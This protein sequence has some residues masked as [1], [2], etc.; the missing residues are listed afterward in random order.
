MPG[1][2]FSPVRAEERN[3]PVQA[4]I[5]LTAIII[6]LVDVSVLGVSMPQFRG[7]LSLSELERTTP[8][9]QDFDFAPSMLG[10]PFSKT[11]RFF[12]QTSY[13]RDY[14]LVFMQHG[15]LWD[16]DGGGYDL[17]FQ[18]DWSPGADQHLEPGETE[19]VTVTVALP[20]SAEN[21]CQ[22]DTGRLIVRRGYLDAGQAG[23]V[24]ECRPS[25]LARLLH[26]VY[27]RGGDLTGYSCMEVDRAWFRFFSH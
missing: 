25:P 26:Q 1:D 22:G 3:L 17:Y 4:K 24:Y 10:E 6:L 23:G 15:G 2:T 7:M 19:T 13:P 20:Q 12:N 21:M 5:V 11:L 9:A 18:A 27:K 14:R 16:C 8:V